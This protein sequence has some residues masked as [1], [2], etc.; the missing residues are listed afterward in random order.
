V[1][2]TLERA[3]GAVRYDANVQEHHH[4]ICSRCGGVEDVY[5]A[6]LRYSLDRRRTLAGAEIRSAEM[7]FHGV[8]GR[9]RRGRR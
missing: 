9:C 7:Q 2:S 3:G 5:L 8:C 1:I 6:D 4:F